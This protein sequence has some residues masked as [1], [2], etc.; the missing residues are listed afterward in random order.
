MPVTSGTLD[1]DGLGEQTVTCEYTDGG[2]LFDSDS[3]TYAIVD[4]S[5][6][7]IGYTV[8]PTNADGA[9]NWYRGTVTLTWHVSE[10]QS[11]NSLEVT[12]C[13]D[14]LIDADQEATDYTCSATSSGGAVAAVRWPRRCATAPKR[15]SPS[16]STANACA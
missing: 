5:E 2:G 4:T 11:P 13:E 1:A 9:G 12:G 7:T 16:P 10:P 8:N 15:W 6:P 3:V 14:Q